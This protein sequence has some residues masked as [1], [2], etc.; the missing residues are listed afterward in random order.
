MHRERE[1]E[2]RER[3]RGP[4]LG[5]TRQPDP[6]AHAQHASGNPE[7][8]EHGAHRPEVAEHLQGDAV[9]L[10]RLR[11]VRPVPEPRDRERPG[12]GAAE[13]AVAGDAERLLPPREAVVRAQVREPPGDVRALAAR[14]LRRRPGDRIS[15]LCDEPDGSPDEHERAAQDQ[16]TAHETAPPRDEPIERRPPRRE[17]DDECPDEGEHGEHAAVGHPVGAEHPVLDEGVSRERPAPDDERGACGDHDP[18][19]VGEPLAAQQEPEGHDHQRA[20]DPRARLREQHRERAAVR[21]ERTPEAELDPAIRR[22]PEAECDRGVREERER[23][24]VADGLPE[25]RDP[26][27][28]GEQRRDRD[29][30]ERPAHRGPD[31]EGED[32]GE[33]PCAGRDRAGQQPESEECEVHETAPEPVPRQVAGD[34]PRDR[35]ARPEGQP[36]R[37]GDRGGGPSLEARQGQGAAQRGAVGEPRDEEGR[38]AD[39][40]ERV[41]ARAATVEHGGREERREGDQE[42]G[43]RAAPARERGSRRRVH[44]ARG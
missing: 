18:Q 10:R 40:C 14:E 27:A 26:V 23:V 32:A 12:A 25:P 15:D 11:R 16:Q 43:L 6:A 2:T 29:A 24:P 38:D 5:G 7:N 8:E 4:A 37:S 9:R 30:E 20:D 39:R 44:R 34:R 42:R 3:C 31:D 35:D 22:E 19:R 36:D 41:D 28:V 21:E 33:P 1:H 13:R 17:R